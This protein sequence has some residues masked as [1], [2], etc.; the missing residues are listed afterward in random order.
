MKRKELA[1]AIRKARKEGEFNRPFS[2]TTLCTAC[3]FLEGE[4]Y[5][6]LS[7]EEIEHFDEDHYGIS[8]WE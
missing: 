7:E 5:E 1:V 8:L 3:I 4:R 2:N 6:S